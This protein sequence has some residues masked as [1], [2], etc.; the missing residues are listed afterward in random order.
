[1]EVKQVIVMRTKYQKPDGTQFS[2]RT[3]KMIAQG[4]HASI[5]FLSHKVRNSLSGRKAE[6]K[7]TDAEM[8]WFEGSFTKVCVRVDSEQELLEIY[9]KALA[10][11]L[12]AHLITDSGRTEFNGVPTHTCCAIGPDEAAKID[13]I[14]GHLKLY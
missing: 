7:L 14:T 2:L 5:S 4:S 13:K 1:M 6:I 12:T 8:A 11:G 9:Q 10:A 3:G